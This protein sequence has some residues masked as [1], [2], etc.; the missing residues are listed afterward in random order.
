[1]VGAFLRRKIGGEKGGG[2]GKIMAESG[3]KRGKEV[4]SGEL[5]GNFTLNDLGEGGKQECFLEL[6]NRALMKRVALSS[7]PNS[8]RIS[9]LAL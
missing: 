7:P 9:Q 6:M 8:A 5:S 3:V 2:A 1:M 4:Y